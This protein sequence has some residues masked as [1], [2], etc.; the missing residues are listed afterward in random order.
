MSGGVPES[1][2]VLR[3]R[4]LSVAGCHSG[5][6]AARAA[7]QSMGQASIENRTRMLLQLVSRAHT[8][9]HQAIMAR[10]LER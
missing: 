6:G 4:L 3:P 2:A 9:N 8:D 5:Q 10:G 1:G 7:S